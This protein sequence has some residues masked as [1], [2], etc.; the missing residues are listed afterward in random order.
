MDH[1]GKRRV[2]G[3][4][5]GFDW[6]PT[7]FVKDMPWYMV[8]VACGIVSPKVA[9]LLCKHVLCQFCYE[10][11]GAQKSLC[12]LDLVPFKKEDVQWTSFS[13]DSLLAL[14][15]FCWNKGKGCEA[16]GPAAEIVNHY[17]QKCDFHSCTCTYCWSEI[18]RRAIV[19]HL[20]ICEPKRLEEPKSDSC[21]VS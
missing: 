13:K 17:H 11:S 20:Q 1:A 8:F 6:R 18:P 3:F 15:I 16:V 14:E 5:C 10:I 9:L 19:D 4:N 7:V 2:C 12:P 21:S